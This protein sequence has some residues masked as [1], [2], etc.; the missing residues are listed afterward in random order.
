MTLH[1]AGQTAAV[2]TNMPAPMQESMH[3]NVSS[4]AG[5]SDGVKGTPTFQHCFHQNTEKK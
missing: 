5:K 3:G 1:T 2:H 4:I